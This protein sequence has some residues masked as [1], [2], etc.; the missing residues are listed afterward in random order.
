MSIFEQK[1]RKGGKH[2][3]WNHKSYHNLNR[4]KKKRKILYNSGWK[5]NY[6]EIFKLISEFPYIIRKDAN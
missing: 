1:K 3:R 2:P 5:L 4:I 6:P